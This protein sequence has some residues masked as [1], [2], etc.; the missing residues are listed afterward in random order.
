MFGNHGLQGLVMEKRAINIH[1]KSIV[2]D[3]LNAVDIKNFNEEYARTLRKGGITAVHITIP[4]TEC[5]SLSQVMN[6]LGLFL[7]RLRL[8]DIH[9]VKLVTTV[10]EIR[11]IKKEEGIA[12]IL[13][14]QGAGF[15]GLDLTIMDVLYRL[16]I[17]TMQPTYQQRNQ[18]GDGSGEKTDV[19][20][21]NLGIQWVEKMNEFG[22]VISLSH[23]G[24]KTSMEVMEISKDPVIFDHSNP[25]ALCNHPRNITDEQIKAC[26]DK[27]GVIGLCPLAMFL[28][29]DKG[30]VDLRVEDYIDHID[31]VVNLT[32]INHVGIGMD[33]VEGGSSTAE[34]ILERRRMNPSLSSKWRRQIEDE[35]LKS[36]RDRLYRYE[37][38]MPWLKSVAELP[39]ATDALVTRGYSDQDIGK[40][41]GENFMRVFEKV[42][43]G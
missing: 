1:E 16:G 6:E 34:Q 26:A 42:W 12:V 7:N 41:L 25:K 37:L 11:E 17:R 3:G 21:S 29:D 28:R 36:G 15:L 5:F 20:L 32:G 40:I 10:K 14:S 38:G 35:F 33:F 4:G 43:G 39:T 9:K 18:F 13:G 31:Y 2:I 23:V 19:G 30:P 22:V 27:D 24:R 8:V